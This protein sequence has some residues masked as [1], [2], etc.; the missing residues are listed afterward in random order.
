MI[1]RNQ[2]IGLIKE[3]SMQKQ[4]INFSKILNPIK[5]SIRKGQYQQAA[6]I[7]AR[8]RGF[9]N[10]RIGGLRNAISGYTDLGKSLTDKQRRAIWRLHNKSV[11]LPEQLVEIQKM[12][13]ENFNTNAGGFER[14]MKTY[15]N[16]E[17]LTSKK[18]AEHVARAASR[19]GTTAA[20]QKNILDYIDSIGL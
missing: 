20:K 9:V 5:K 12:L 15:Q 17:D 14:Y 16:F 3:A 19:A 8:L 11:E 1:T 2:F 10:G 18:I 7:T 6:E 4:A 13:R